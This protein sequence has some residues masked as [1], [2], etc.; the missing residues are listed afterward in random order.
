M[1][2]VLLVLAF[3][4]LS[5]WSFGQIKVYPKVGAIVSSQDL[6]FGG[7]ERDNY[8]IKEKLGFVVGLGVEK[9]LFN[10]FALSGDVQFAQLGYID[11]FKTQWQDWEEVYNTNYVLLPL[12][13][14]YF[15]KTDAASKFFLAAGPYGGVFVNGTHTSTHDEKYQGYVSTSKNKFNV[16]D[17]YKYDRFDWGFQFGGGLT[18]M[19]WQNEFVLE[20]KYA[21]GV[22]KVHEISY[23]HW[24][25]GSY[26]VGSDGK[27][28]FLTISLAYTLPVWNQKQE[29]SSGK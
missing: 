14:K 15:V 1:E 21:F 10:R 5:F 11:H 24:A 19:L 12:S 17:G 18:F 27:N 13:L 8:H 23:N 6:D 28:Q 4:I 29:V 22:P 9:E 7:V 3:S 2:K 25:R 26:P 16:N 20:A